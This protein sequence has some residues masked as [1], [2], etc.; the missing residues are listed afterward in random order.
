M[1]DLQSVST[2]GW[3]AESTIEEDL[4]PISTF[5]WYFTLGDIEPELVL[6]IIYFNNMQLM[7]ICDFQ[8][9]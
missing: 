6:E 1:T 3:F 4:T 2:F 5:G 9:N 7:Q 8:L